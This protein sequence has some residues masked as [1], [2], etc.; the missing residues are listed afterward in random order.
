MNQCIYVDL[1]I[2]PNFIFTLIMSPIL[3][4]NYIC[5]FRLTH[6]LIFSFHYFVNYYLFIYLFFHFICYYYYYYYIILY[7]YFII[8]F[9]LSP[10]S[11]LPSATHSFSLLPYPHVTT[12]SHHLSSVI[13]F[14]SFYFSSFSKK[15]DE[16]TILSLG[17]PSS[18]LFSS[19]FIFS[20]F[21]S[22]S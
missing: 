7:F 5:Y 13:F 3:N 11:T 16:T 21:F 15:L 9:F 22:P 19:I 1:K 8:L 20:F 6:P 14:I 10:L 12:C 17:C 18:Q 2:C 4:L